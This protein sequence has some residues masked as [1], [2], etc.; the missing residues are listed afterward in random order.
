MRWFSV[1]PAARTCDSVTPGIGLDI[2][3]PLR[4]ADTRPPAEPPVQ[5]NHS[6]APAMTRLLGPMHDPVEKCPIW[7]RVCALISVI[8]FASW[9]ATYSVCVEVS[10]AISEAPLSPVSVLTIW[11]EKLRTTIE[12][13]PGPPETKTC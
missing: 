3:L 12:D 8:S 1:P 4:L 7:P 6:L 2:P 13:V 5:E 10:R 9:R 11:P